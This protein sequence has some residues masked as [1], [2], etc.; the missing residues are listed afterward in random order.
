MKKKGTKE[1]KKNLTKKTASRRMDVKKNND[2]KGNK[3]RTYN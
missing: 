2:A 1:M 3:K